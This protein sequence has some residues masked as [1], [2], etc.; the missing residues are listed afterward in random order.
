MNKRSATVW[1]LALL[2]AA[3]VGLTACGGTS[4]QA[5]NKA[6]NTPPAST[7]VIVGDYCGTVSTSPNGVV[8][9]PSQAAIEQ[10]FAAAFA[11]CRSATLIFHLTGTDTADVHTLTTQASGQACAVHDAYQH[12]IIPQPPAAPQ[13]YQCTGLKQYTDGLLLTGCGGEGSVW[14]GNPAQQP[15]A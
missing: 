13:T 10:C 8:N 4:S 3:S 12:E 7:P 9:S 11:T 14:V 2:C 5:A 1:L 6:T 15:A